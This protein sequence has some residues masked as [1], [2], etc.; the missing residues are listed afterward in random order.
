MKASDI[1]SDV[2]VR[3]PNGFGDEVLIGWINATLREVWRVVAK[4]A[5]LRAWINPGAKLFKLPEGVEFYALRSVVVNG[6]EYDFA[7]DE[8]DVRDRIYFKAG[9]DLFGIHP[10]PET[11]EGRS[12]IEIRYD[13]RPPAVIGQDDEIEILGDYVE[14]LTL[15][16]LGSVA[17][18]EGDVAMGNNFVADFNKLLAKAEREKWEK[19]PLYPTIKVVQ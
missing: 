11:A 18:A 16:V 10:M 4:E 3:Y 15:G 17:K 8:D 7:R 2:R 12:T 14:L 1:I 19:E 6:K 5:V 13:K 9:E